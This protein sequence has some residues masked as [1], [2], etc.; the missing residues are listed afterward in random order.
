MKHHAEDASTHSTNYSTQE[1]MS[2]K[3]IWRTIWF[4]H[5]C[6]LES[7]L[8]TQKFLSLFRCMWLQNV[9]VPISHKCVNLLMWLWR[10]IRNGLLLTFLETVLHYAAWGGY[11]E[12]VL[13]LIAANADVNAQNVCYFVVSVYKDKRMRISSWF[14]KIMAKMTFCDSECLILQIEQCWH[15][16]IIA[17]DLIYFKN[18]VFWWS[19][20]LF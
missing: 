9:S 7:Q 14:L 13:L 17:I 1:P 16:L 4:V 15:I 3:G 6:S 5:T 12:F 2:M 18:F 20:E 10:E 19:F 11:S 8:S